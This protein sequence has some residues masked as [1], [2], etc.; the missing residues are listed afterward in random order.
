MQCRVPP[1]RILELGTAGTSIRRE[2]FNQ[3]GSEA[4][5]DHVCNYGPPLHKCI[6]RTILGFAVDRQ[7][8]LE[9]C[10]GQHKPTSAALTAPL[11]ENYLA[12][13]H[14]TLMGCLHAREPAAPNLP[15]EPTADADP[16]PP[17]TPRGYVFGLPRAVRLFRINNLQNEFIAPTS[18]RSSFFDRFSVQFDGISRRCWRFLA[19]LRR[20]ARGGTTPSRSTII[21]RREREEQ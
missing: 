14:N 16:H 19:G 12:A 2:A 18:K 3:V 1:V 15:R 9:P 11:A 17:Y 6:V 5:R 13:A 8:A 10:R 4:A 20:S 21:A 7:A